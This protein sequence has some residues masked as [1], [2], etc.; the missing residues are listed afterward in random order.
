MF[1]GLENVAVP[2]PTWKKNTFVIR[3]SKTGYGFGE[4]VLMIGEDGRCVIDDECS[5]R[6]TVKEILGYLVDGAKFVSDDWEP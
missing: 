6:E 4:L 1:E 3:W 2:A 5:S